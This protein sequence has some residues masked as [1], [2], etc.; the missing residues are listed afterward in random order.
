VTSLDDACRSRLDLRLAREQADSRLPSLVAGIVRDGELSWSGSAGTVGG[1]APGA[2]TQY[3]IG[4]V[5]KTF[6]AVAVLR[7]RDEG[8][9]DLDDRVEDHVPGTPVG[10]ATVA[11]LLSHASGLQAETD[12]PWWE[13]S[14]GGPWP[15]L[16]GTMAPSWSRD[17]PGRRFHYSN[18]GYAVLG[19]L[20][21]R[22][23]AMP[24]H[25]AVRSELLEPLGMR[26]TTTRPQEPHAKGLAVH[27]W[28]DAVLPE[29]E[30]DAGAMAPAG[31]LWSTV[32]DLARWAGFLSGDGAHVLAADTLAEMCRPLVVEDT[33]GDPWTGG[34]GL[35]LQIWNLDGRRSYG[36]SGSMPGFLAVLRVDA[37]SADAAIV[38]T[39]STA[40]L[41]AAFPTDLLDLVAE[42][43]PRQPAVWQ[44]AA[45]EA[46]LLALTGAWFWGPTPVAVHAGADGGLELRD[47][48]RRA[49]TSHF[50]PTGDGTWTG[51]DGYYAGETLRVVRRAGGEVSHLDVASFVLTRTP[52]DPL[53]DVPGGVDQG[54]WRA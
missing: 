26:R 16:A 12:G 18:V 39:N 32:G 31:Q 48:G 8:L 4:S 44:P 15:E 25:D 46:G 38:A 30:H 13:R 6:V 36:H 53:A 20:V 41:S 43:A 23:R 29:P 10:R 28:A 37:E 45:V 19:E 47:L 14:P 21:A 9:V 5:T 34:Y 42:H 11:Q 17:R 54:G 50:R 22:H 3:R 7:L 33:P 27:P 52:Y 35:G 24:W 40:G 51:S 1:R 2:D 49:R